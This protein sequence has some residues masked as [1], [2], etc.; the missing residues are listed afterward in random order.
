VHLVL[1]G[2]S[3][4]HV[5]KMGTATDAQ[6]ALWDGTGEKPLLPVDVYRLQGVARLAGV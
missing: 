1:A 4:R 6:W 5:V 3:E 2:V